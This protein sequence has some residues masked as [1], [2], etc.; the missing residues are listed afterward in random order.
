MALRMT[1]L[2]GAHYG[3]FGRI[4][5]H[6]RIKDFV[7]ADGDNIHAQTVADRTTVPPGKRLR[8]SW[9]DPGAMGFKK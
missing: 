3:R 7:R 5:F 6:Q 1:G 4:G 9:G 8:F 2:G